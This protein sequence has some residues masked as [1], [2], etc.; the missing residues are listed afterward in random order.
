M[1]VEPRQDVDPHGD[2]RLENFIA[3]E[4]DVEVEIHSGTTETLQAIIGNA[5]GHSV[6]R[7][8]IEGVVLIWIENVPEQLC[9][10]GEAGDK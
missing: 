7:V 1:V 2:P 9:F 5:F 10:E 8:M 6:R 3:R 4:E